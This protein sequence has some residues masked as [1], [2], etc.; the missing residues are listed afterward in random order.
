MK[1]AARIGDKGKGDCLVGHDDVPK[2]Q[3]KPFITTFVTGSPDVYINNRF[4]VRSGDVGQT[5]CGHRTK[6]ATG[7][8]TV[9]VN[10]RFIHRISDIGKVI[11]DGDTY[12]TF[13]ASD[14]VYIGD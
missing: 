10:Y 12:K 7:S 6:A 2:G 8:G 13:T 11:D 1:A 9:Y 3:R 14:D 5:D 4:V